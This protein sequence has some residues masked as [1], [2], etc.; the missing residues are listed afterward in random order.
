MLCAIT[1]YAESELVGRSFEEITH[2]DD[3]LADVELAR[4]LARGELPRYQIEKRYV[5][6]DGSVV[7]VSLSRSVL[8]DERGAPLRYVGIVQDLTERKALE[9]ALRRSERHFRALIENGRDIVLVLDR[10]GR[11]IYVSPANQRWTGWPPE[12]RLG[13]EG[14]ELIHPDDLGRV[15]GQLA[16]LLRTPGGSASAE[17]RWKHRDGHWIWV[18][19]TAHQLVDDPAVRGVVVS[20][21]DVTE[22][23]AIEEKLERSERYFR[24][25][26][27]ATQ[28]VVTILDEHAVRTYVSPS[29]EA[30]LGFTP[31]E[32]V[33]RHGLDS[34]HPDDLPRVAH[35]LAELL[36]APGARAALELRVRHKDGS[37]RHA[38]SVGHNLLDDAAVR[39]I[40][41]HSRDSTARHVAEAQLAAS[42][43]Y[44]RALLENALDLVF[45]TDLSGTTRSVSTSIA[46]V[47]GHAPSELVGRSV[48]EIVHP[49]D[50]PRAAEAFA[51]SAPQHGAREVVEVRL[52]H[53][54]GGVR[55]VEVVGQSFVDD[56]VVD[57]VVLNARDVTERKLAEERLA[58]S[59]A[60]F[61]ALIEQVSDAVTVLEPDGALRYLSPAIHRI[62][63]YEPAEL[64]GSALLD[65]VHP[66]DR[67]KIAADV[68]AWPVAP[69]EA[70][71]STPARFRARHKDG[72]WRT[73]EGTGRISFEDPLVR[74][75]IGSVRDVSDRVAAEEERERLIGELRAALE[76]VKTLEGL[77]PI[78]SS[79]KRV[80]D[81]QGYWTQIESYLS[82]HSRAEFSHGICPRCAKELYP[83]FFADK[84]TDEI[85]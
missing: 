12:E 38:D 31:A 66:D 67:A 4:L 17:Y 82:A 24:A 74:G 60:Y 7:W 33:G 64:V 61:R 28:D 70:A 15:K 34:V 26:I 36:R 30:V 40:V 44:H 14:F 18:E 21:R 48:F 73:L 5:R 9:E 41:I 78:C 29:V 72:S 52:L 62:L 63:G 2:P 23:R 58:R 37:W 79:C 54:E 11:N 47:T 43:R 56:P 83:D 1:G 25:L 71:G 65:L 42:E 57:G 6:K 10:E 3:V 39:G 50:V 80:R 8:R 53:K 84:P 19:A 59:E 49:D 22:R 55:H 69:E 75:V 35:V 51:R 27:E 45:V 81:D 16:E 77:L 76:Q 32:L 20:A 46:R 68:A 13:R 85:R